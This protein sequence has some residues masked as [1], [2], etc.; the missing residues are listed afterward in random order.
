MAQTELFP[1]IMSAAS[2]FHNLTISSA[3]EMIDS[4]LPL[5]L[6]TDFDPGSMP[7]CD[8]K[9]MQSLGCIYGLTPQKVINAS[10]INSAFLMNASDAYDTIGKNKAANLFVTKK[11]PTYEYFPYAFSS[12]LIEMVIQG[13]EIQ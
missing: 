3:R 1:V 2:F 11:I 8:M 9:F 13:G 6:A 10:T 4:G 7:T 5:A 12:D